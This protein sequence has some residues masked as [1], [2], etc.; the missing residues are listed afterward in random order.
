M[1]QEYQLDFGLDPTFV[2]PHHSLNQNFKR[3]SYL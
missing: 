1:T 2:I 3:I